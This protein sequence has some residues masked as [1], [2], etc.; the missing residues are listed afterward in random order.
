MFGLCAIEII[1]VPNIEKCKHTAVYPSSA[2]FH[3][4]LMVVHRI[5]FCDGVGKIAKIIFLVWLAV[6]A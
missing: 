5:S 3:Q 2:L 6:Y 1:T 4:I